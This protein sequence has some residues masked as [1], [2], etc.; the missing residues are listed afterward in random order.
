MQMDK[1]NAYFQSVDN[2]LGPIFREAVICIHRTIMHFCIV[3]NFKSIHCIDKCFLK[4]S[5]ECSTPRYSFTS[6]IS[7]AEKRKRHFSYKHIYIYIYIY[8]YI[9]ISPETTNSIRI[10]VILDTVLYIPYHV[11][12]DRDST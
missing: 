11:Y 2:K 10:S 12:A 7:G 4:N 5:G 6:V 1:R 9:S 8:I 3:C